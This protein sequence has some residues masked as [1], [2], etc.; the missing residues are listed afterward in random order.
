[1][2]SG[3]DDCDDGPGTFQR[4]PV[5]QTI[6][7][8][9]SQ[10][11]NLPVINSVSVTTEEPKKPPKESPVIEL[12][13]LDMAPDTMK[14]TS[15]ADDKT[16]IAM[17]TTASSAH[18]RP[19]EPAGQR[20]ENGT[21]PRSRQHTV[22]VMSVAGQEVKQ[23]FAAARTADNPISLDEL[24]KR[25]SQLVS[26]MEKD[27][28]AKLDKTRKDCAKQ[29]QAQKEQAEADQQC[30][31]MNLDEMKKKIE[32]FGARA[33]QLS[34][35]TAS[36]MMTPEDTRFLKLEKNQLEMELRTVHDAYKNMFNM[37]D[38]LKNLNK[39][40]KEDN[41]QLREIESTLKEKIATGQEKYM[42]MVDQAT[43]RLNQANECIASLERKSEDDTI[44]LRAKLK[45]TELQ[46]STTLQQ[47]EIKRKEC[48][49][50]N[51]ICQAL[52]AKAEIHSDT[53]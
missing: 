4:S 6:I 5:Q 31:S 10:T 45:K 48:M 16:K 22:T 42:K 23:T 52:L 3:S 51:E 19:A 24:E 50:L 35:M 46:L 9:H 15:H 11:R 44:T 18:P 13:P 40:L 32:F 49:E 14:K 25:M 27:N 38:K 28:I 29:I 53:E 26:K 33:P 17:P 43:E 41:A 1:M 20:H 7:R 39:D 8:P 30:L 36:T 2:D 47:L 12:P 34:Q 21:A 37:Y